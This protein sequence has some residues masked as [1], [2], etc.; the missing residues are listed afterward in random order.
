MTESPSTP[1]RQP[2]L[3]TRTEGSRGARRHPHISLF[4]PD[5][6]GGGAERVTVNLARGMSELGLDVDLLVVNAVGPYLAHVPE[7]V[8]LVDLGTRR[9]SLSVFALRDY[10][11][12]HQPPVLLT[13]LH[14]ANLAVLITKRLFGLETR[15]IPTIHNTLSVERERRRSMKQHVQHALM[16]RCYP[17]ADGIVAVS[18]AVAD[19]FAATT[20]VRREDVTTI[21]NPV[22]TPEL[23]E[24]AREAP[25]HPWFAPGSPPVVLGIGRLEFQKDF[26]NL[27]RAFQ[28]V[29]AHRE[30][31]LMILGEGDRRTELERLVEQLGLQDSVALPGFV[32]NPYAFLGQAAVFALSSRW[33]GLPT[34][35]IEAMALGVPMVATD[36]PS[37]PREILEGGRFGQ[38]VPVENSEA[39][40]AAIARA[41]DERGRRTAPPDVWS[42]YTLDAAVKRYLEY[43]KVDWDG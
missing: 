18:E 14:H 6:T 29:K 38:L 21:Y 26:E 22:V 24:S 15:I 4:I 32:D 8:N 23:L 19:D 28:R 27:I 12:S 10:L 16:S 40:A 2:E 37:G 35:L 39:L 7:D 17:W 30:A 36:C 20:G 31:R 25:A 41:L 9:T 11:R 5:L 34:V 1:S 42:R 33:E 43:A 13:S 3:P